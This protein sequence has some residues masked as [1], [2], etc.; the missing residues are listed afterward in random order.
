MEN[1]MNVKPE[2]MEMYRALKVVME[3][4]FVA[5]WLEKNTPKTLEQC[6]KAVDGFEKVYYYG[7]DP[8]KLDIKWSIDQARKRLERPLT[9][10]EIEAA[11]PEPWK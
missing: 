9:A 7:C 5:G 10:Q 1:Q 8:L 3:D 11:G 4:R 2:V 6:E